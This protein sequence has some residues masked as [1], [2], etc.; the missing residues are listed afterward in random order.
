MRYEERCP[1][2]FPGDVNIKMKKEGKILAEKYG[3]KYIP[4]SKG[5]YIMEGDEIKLRNCLSQWYE[6]WEIDEILM[7]GSTN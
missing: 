4:I 6:D 3:L 1:G 5:G 7:R 2:K